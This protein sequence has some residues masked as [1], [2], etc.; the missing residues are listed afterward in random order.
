MLPP[1]VYRGFEFIEDRTFGSLVPVAAFREIGDRISDRLEL[2]D[3]AVEFRNVLER[4]PLYIPAGA[5]A[6][7]VEREQRAGHRQVVGCWIVKAQWI[8]RRSSAGVITP[9]WRRR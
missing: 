1:S 6:V 8:A 5:A 4:E 2:G 9:P 7:A 3:L